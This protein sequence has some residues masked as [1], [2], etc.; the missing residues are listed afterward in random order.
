MT[1]LSL[2]ISLLEVT[3][4]LHS[5][6]KVALSLARVDVKGRG[7][8]WAE[9]SGCTTRPRFLPPTP[10]NASLHYPCDSSSDLPP[11]WE[12]LRE[13]S[14]QTTG[15]YKC[16][17]CMSAAPPTGLSEVTQLLICCYSTVYFLTGWNV[18]VNSFFF[19]VFRQCYFRLFLL[20]LSWLWTLLSCCLHSLW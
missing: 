4:M 8:V 14:E 18:F 1:P 5:I 17:G 20:F 9:C 10:M 11:V 13:K 12:I 16:S 15:C 3:F 6:E 2:K 7:H 19:I